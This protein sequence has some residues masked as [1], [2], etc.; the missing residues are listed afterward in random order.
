MEALIADDTAS[1]I[2]KAISTGK[3]DAALE[4]EFAT[5]Y[6]SANAVIGGEDRGLADLSSPRELDESVAPIGEK[7]YYKGIHEK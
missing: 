3:Q 2:S 5:K 4:K 7:Q 1:D 6:M